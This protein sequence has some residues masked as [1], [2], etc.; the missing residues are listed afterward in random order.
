[1]RDILER[2][3]LYDLK[4]GGSVVKNPSANAGDG[5]DV[6]SLPESGRCPRGGNGNPVFWPGKL[7]GQ[8]SLM[9]YSPWGHERVR[10]NLVTKQPLECSK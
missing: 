2:L 4:A 8:R 9:D 7:H 10:H 6:G 5:R 3:I 1:M